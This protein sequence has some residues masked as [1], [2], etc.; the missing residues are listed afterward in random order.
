MAFEVDFQYFKTQFWPRVAT[1]QKGINAD[2]VWT[3][4][5]SYIKGAS[6]AHEYAGWYVSQY[7]Y[8]Y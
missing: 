3:Q 6:D 2:L 8:V 5:Y 1:Y 7:N 4:I